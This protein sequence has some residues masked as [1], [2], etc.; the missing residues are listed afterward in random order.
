MIEHD[1]R[2]NRTVGEGH[3]RAPD[4]VRLRKALKKTGHS[5]PAPQPSGIYD[6]SAHDAV[7]RF[8]H[9]FGLKEDGIVRPGGP[10]QTA[11][12]IAHA[13]IEAGGREGYEAVRQPLAVLHRAGLRYQRMDESGRGAA[14]RWINSEGRP[15]AP[16]Q[17]QG[18]LNKAERPG[19]HLAMYPDRDPITGQRRFPGQRGGI[20]EGGGGAGG[21][22]GNLPA[23]KLFNVLFRYLFGEI[24]KKSGD[25]DK[26]SGKPTPSGR[27][28][29]PENPPRQIPPSPA[30]PPPEPRKEKEQ[31]GSEKSP[32]FILP[33]ATPVE[34]RPGVLIFPNH[35]DVFNNPHIVENRKG[36]D[37]T[38]DYN[39]EARDWFLTPERKEEGW[40]HVGGGRVRTPGIGH[41][42]GDDPEDI[43]EEKEEEYISNQA[44]DFEE[45]LGEKIDGRKGSNYVDLTFY[46]ENTEEWV[47][48]Q[49]VDVDENGK[50]TQRELDNAWSI[51]KR[52]GATVILIKKPW[53]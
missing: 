30:E 49:T 2:V 21:G 41:N 20:L 53:Q 1:F 38:R 45:L 28:L 25:T 22:R 15:V 24:A 16:G 7:M 23:G 8:Q 5:R 52:T 34:G 4:V 44:K 37:R 39:E 6:R 11:I 27:T 40:K 46:N 36:D 19:T 32:P 17:I 29:P 51:W 10:T 3:S 42:S 9:D 33:G 43:V 31:P 13:A 35:S 26:S 12:N 50:P 18:L 14:G 48:I 47:R